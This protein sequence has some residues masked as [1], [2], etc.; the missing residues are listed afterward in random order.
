MGGK[1]VIRYL[2][3]RKE[4]R[5]QTIRYPLDRKDGLVRPNLVEPTPHIRIRS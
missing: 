5:A 2:R 3:Q 4:K 1:E